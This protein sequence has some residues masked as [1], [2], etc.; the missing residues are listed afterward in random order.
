MLVSHKVPCQTSQGPYPTLVLLHGLG[1]DER[2]LEPV[3]RA[4]SRQWQ[5][6]LLRAPDPVP[7]FPGFQWYR[8]EALGHPDLTALDNSL[9]LLWQ[10]LVALR[11]APDTDPGHLVLGGFSQ[12]A[13]TSAAFIARYPDFGLAAL[14]LLSGYLPDSTDIPPLRGFPVFLAH[15]SQDP[16][17]PHAWGMDMGERMTAAGAAVEAHTYPMGH[18]IH[19]EELHDLQNFLQRL[20]I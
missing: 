19:P 5:T 18:A 17:L 1:A 9:D 12:G 16:V 6:V 4:L 3:G 11:E 14:T 2:D 7:N 8:M 15:G 20:L 10:T 13:L